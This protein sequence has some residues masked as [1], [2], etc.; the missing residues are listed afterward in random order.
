MEASST[1]DTPVPM[2]M[3]IGFLKKYKVTLNYP[4]NTIRFEP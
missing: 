4:A 3:V 2:G 1:H